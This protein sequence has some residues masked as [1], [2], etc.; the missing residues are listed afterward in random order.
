MSV[1]GGGGGEDGWSNDSGCGE[2]G[3]GVEEGLRRDFE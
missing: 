3:E 1:E 2:Y